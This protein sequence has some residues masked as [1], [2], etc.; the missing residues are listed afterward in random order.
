[1]N[2]ILARQLRRSGS[3]G[4]EPPK[5]WQGFLSTVSEAFDHADTDRT[6]LE[7]SMKLASSELEERNEQLKLEMADR[8]RMGA[9]LRLAQKLESTGQL[10]AGI[11]H[12][13]NTPIQYVGD[14]V[15]FLASAF[16]DL[17]T[18]L[19]T[20]DGLLEALRRGESGP[21]LAGTIVEA[22]E[23]ADLAYLAENVPAAIG[24]ATDGVER[25]AT[26][27]RAMKDFAHPDQPGMAS[28][29]INKA[30]VSTL[31]VGRNEYKYVADVVTDLGDLPPMRCHLGQ[32]NQ[33]FLN[34]VINAAHAIA[35]QRPGSDVR[36]NIC[37][38]SRKEDDSIVISIEDDGGG[39]PEEIQSRIFDPF[40]TTKEVGR[41]TGQGLAIAR[42]IIVDRHGGS[43]TFTVRPGVGTTF[44]IRL[45]IKGSD[46]D[47]A[48]P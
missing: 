27:V 13:I 32:I 42:T 11:A 38:R 1:M 5:D 35:D 9:E 24:R 15:A 37:V 6:L 36:G 45:P 47:E 17:F 18:Y 28:V 29:D 46:D 7:R 30:I 33:V 41:G 19:R 2:R 26:I 43:L 25:V 31:T 34:I 10:A 23:R 12:E 16:D 39:I 14:S 48:T 22:A 21:S 8:E 44:F 3:E 40:F 4:G 20:I